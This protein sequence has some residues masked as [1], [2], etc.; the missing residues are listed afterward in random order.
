MNQSRTGW[1]ITGT[2]RSRCEGLAHDELEGVGR[3]GSARDD[4][5]LIVELDTPTSPI[6]P[7]CPSGDDCA[8]DAVAVDHIEQSV[9]G[10]DQKNARA[11]RG[12]P[13]REDP[14]R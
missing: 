3:G 9:L 11:R 7:H 2:A 8:A 14:K 1:P 4:H 10:I 12:E 13:L 6:A 5:V